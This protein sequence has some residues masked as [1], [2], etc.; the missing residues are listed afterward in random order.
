MWA[1][2]WLPTQIRP[3]RRSWGSRELRSLFRT[4]AAGMCGCHKIQDSDF[5]KS[6]TVTRDYP[7]VGFRV[8]RFGDRSGHCGSL[9]LA[10][11]RATASKFLHGLPALGESL[12]TVGHGAVPYALDGKRPRPK[13]PAPAL[14][15]GSVNCTFSRPCS[16]VCRMPPRS[17]L[18]AKQRSTISAR[19]L[20][21]S[22][23][24]PELSRGV[25]R[26]RL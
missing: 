10:L 9:R 14:S 19:S 13:S 18:W 17:R 12:V 23:V 15:T 20:T 11:T 16:L 2:R 21:V 22:R 6:W 5:S 26:Q 3:D 4:G 25:P 24:P 8:R 7:T 1:F